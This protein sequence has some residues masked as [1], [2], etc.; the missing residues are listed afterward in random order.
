MCHYRG[1]DLQSLQKENRK[2]VKEQ[3]VMLRAPTASSRL[4]GD[5][6]SLVPAPKR[7]CLILSFSAFARYPNG[8]VV[9]YFCCKDR[10]VCPA[11]Q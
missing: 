6:Q 1:E 9:H 5:I 3:S 10:T 7:L 2:Q 4:L 8:V 11:E